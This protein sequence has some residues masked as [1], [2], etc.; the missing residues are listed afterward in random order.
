MGRA[1]DKRGQNTLGKLKNLETTDLKQEPSPGR[2][3][4]TSSEGDVQEMDRWTTKA[5]VKL[6]PQ[7]LGC[8]MSTAPSL[9]KL[10]LRPKPKHNADLPLKPTLN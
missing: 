7:L 6:M 2:R 5:R 9:I 8:D 3:E 4:E 10:K 1:G